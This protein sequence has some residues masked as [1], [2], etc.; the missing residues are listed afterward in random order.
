MKII[1]NNKKVKIVEV[2]DETMQISKNNSFKFKQLIETWSVLKFKGDA[3]SM[4]GFAEQCDKIQADLK[5]G[6]K[7]RETYKYN[8]NEDFK[9]TEW[10]I[11]IHK[12]NSNKLIVYSVSR[13][14]NDLVSHVLKCELDTKSMEFVN[15]LCTDRSTNG[16]EF[17]HAFKAWLDVHVDLEKEVIM[18]KQNGQK[19]GCIWT[20]GHFW[21]DK[22]KKLRNHSTE[23][24]NFKMNQDKFEFPY[25]I[26]EDKCET[27]KSIAKE[28]MVIL[29]NNADNFDE[30][31]DAVYASLFGYQ[32]FCRGGSDEKHRVIKFMLGCNNALYNPNCQKTFG[33]I[34]KEHKKFAKPES[35]ICTFDCLNKD[36]CKKVHPMFEGI[37]ICDDGI[38]CDD[39]FCTSVCH[40]DKDVMNIDNESKF[41]AA[42]EKAIKNEKPK[43]SNRPSQSRYVSKEPTRTN[44]T[45]DSRKP[46]ECFKGDNCSNY[47]KGT[48][49]F[50]HPIKKCIF[51]SCNKCFCKFDHDKR[52]TICENGKNCTRSQCYTKKQSK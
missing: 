26:L 40:T 43:F 5:K 9:N 1:N 51:K 2:V 29:M 30:N 52:S 10:T 12:I 27:L 11:H 28:V 46:K 17:K 41:L 33:S 22:L 14:D 3:D 23:D 15:H 48:C 20:I 25:Q 31:S 34:I 47:K 42:K 4:H 21:C 49:S 24:N 36:I 18:D 13:D 32:K 6:K 19:P 38:D 50:F 35:N 16:I 8:C 7:I 45:T 37:T 39:K 44:K